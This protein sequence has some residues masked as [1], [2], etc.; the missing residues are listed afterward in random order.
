MIINENIEPVGKAPTYKRKNTVTGLKFKLLNRNPQGNLIGEA[1][2]KS[3]AGLLVYEAFYLR[4]LVVTNVWFKAE[5]LEFFVETEKD[6]LSLNSLHKDWMFKY[7]V[8]WGKVFHAITVGV[9]T[10]YEDQYTNITEEIQKYIEKYEDPNSPRPDFWYEKV[11]SYTEGHE[12]ECFDCGHITH[13]V[14]N[15]KF[16]HNDKEYIEEVFMGQDGTWDLEPLI[17]RFGEDVDPG[18]MSGEEACPKC[19]SIAIF[20]VI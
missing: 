1:N 20:P 19:H 18:I 12:T 14:S 13:G 11:N 16:V 5:T 8:N 4:G 17:E 7:K 9:Y 3:R 10:L 15:W 6:L 2:A